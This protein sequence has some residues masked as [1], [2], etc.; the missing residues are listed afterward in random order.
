MPQVSLHSNHKSRPR[1]TV[2]DVDAGEQYNRRIFQIVVQILFSG[3]YTSCNPLACQP[4]LPSLR[5]PRLAPI[6]Y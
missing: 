1:L 4:T 6:P 3:L 2:S 5:S